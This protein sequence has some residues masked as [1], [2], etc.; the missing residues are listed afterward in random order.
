[1]TKL[2]LRMRFAWWLGVLSAFDLV[3][4]TSRRKPVAGRVLVV[5]LDAIGDFVL[6]VE[7]ARALRAIY[8]RG[9]Y[10]LTLLGNRL[11]TPLARDLNCF[12]E[13][14]ELDR[15]LFVLNPLYRFAILRRVAA[16]GFTTAIHPTFGRDFLWGDAV[17]RAAQASESI[18]FDGTTY[19]LTRVEKW[20]SDRWYTKLVPAS[21][22]TVTVL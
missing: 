7:G 3:A 18:G 1:M 19:L 16:G 13:V 21:C 10:H 22:G 15:K 2:R 20:L 17:V 6:W 5:R 12:D 8:P 11:W 14:W 9:R 4:R